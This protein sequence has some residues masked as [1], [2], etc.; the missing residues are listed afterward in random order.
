M[1]C[2]EPSVGELP[3]ERRSEPRQG[4]GMLY[5]LLGALLLLRGWISPA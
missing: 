2:P 4:E 5:L 3:P 1:L